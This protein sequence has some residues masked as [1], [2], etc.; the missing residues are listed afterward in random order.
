MSEIYLNI[1]AVY[2]QILFHSYHT[3]MFK[4]T[5]GRK[6]KS[7]TAMVGSELSSQ[8]AVKKTSN[9]SCPI[10]NVFLCLDKFVAKHLLSCEHY[11]KVLVSNES[12]FYAL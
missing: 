3:I 9:C 4:R 1:F 12:P 2:H 8:E 11:A 5:T 6:I 7:T 10:C